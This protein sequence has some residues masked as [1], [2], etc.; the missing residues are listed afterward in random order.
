MEVVGANGDKLGKRAGHAAGPLQHEH[1]RPC[2]P[3]AMALIDEHDGSNCQS[4]VCEGLELYNERVVARA[5]QQQY[6]ESGLAR[7]RCRGNVG[8]AATC[9]QLGQRDESHGQIKTSICVVI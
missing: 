7:E 9:R 2:L 1:F 8:G 6:M 4:I 3:N 5:C